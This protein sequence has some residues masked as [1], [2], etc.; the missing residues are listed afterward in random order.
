MQ[1]LTLFMIVQFAGLLIA[2][3]FYNTVPISASTI[4]FR[5][6]SNQSSFNFTLISALLYVIIIVI[7]SI[8]LIFI[9]KKFK[10]NKIFYLIE[11]YIIFVSTFF[12]FWL[13]TRLITNTKLFYLFGNTITTSIAISALLSVGLIIA[14]NKYQK[15][16]NTVAILAS[17][18]VG[19]LIGLNF[20]FYF[21]FIFMIFLAVYDFI[22]VFITK[23]M[24]TMAK[25]V[26][27]KNLAFLIGVNEIEALDKSNFTKQE[28]KEYN[29]EKKYINQT[30]LQ[31]LINKNML[32]VAARIELGTGDLAVP[33]MVA[34]SAL[35]NIKLSFFIIFGS[36]FGLMLTM[37]ILKKYKRALPAIP[38]LLFG[39]CVSLLIYFLLFHAL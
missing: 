16:R 18:G 14:K 23:H 13:L 35:P 4:S 33:L 39:I 34:V 7:F 5:P 26:S 36:I 17:I 9:F 21:A 1:I 37:L 2:V 11:A 29:K 25:A 27:E 12:I 32:P 31:K 38:P 8:I 3:I 19:A 10:S 30:G 22:A 6:S 24:I 20:P 15:L 28:L